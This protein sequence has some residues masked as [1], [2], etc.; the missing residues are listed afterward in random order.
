MRFEAE[1]HALLRP[2]VASYWGF[3][4]EFSQRRDFSVTPDRFVELIFF[5]DPPYVDD[6]NERVRL[7][8]CTLV[9]LLEEP[10]RLVLDGSMRCACV[11]FHPWAAGIILPQAEFSTRPWHDCS[12]PFSGALAAV[13]D[14]L[15]R[16][17]WAEI[18]ARFDAELLPRFALAHPAER[19]D[20][21]RPFV[22]APDGT[23]VT[24]AS[25]AASQAR[26]RR[27]IEREVRSLSNRSPKQLASLARFQ[28]V[29]DALWERPETALDRLAAEAGYADQAHLSRHFRRYAAQS[30][31]AFARDCRRLR[32][33]IPD[34]DVAFVQD[35]G[36]ADD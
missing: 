21:V 19:L 22:A 13:S 5:I 16:D 9:P 8:I 6:A 10:L 7:P 18:A 2:Y 23:T 1:P 11:R 30:P 31:R 32:A 20:A 24:T 3:A 28:F 33:S 29:R 35:A 36:S 15:G 26:S 17:A 14:A 27:Q 34:E 25:V 12:A 4:R